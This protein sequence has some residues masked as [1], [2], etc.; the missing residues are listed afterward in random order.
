[1][2]ELVNWTVAPATVAPEESVTVPETSPVTTVCAGI[3]I[4]TMIMQAMRNGTAGKRRKTRDDK[5][6]ASIT[7]NRVTNE[8]ACVM[9]I[10]CE[11]MDSPVTREHC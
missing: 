11:H 4:G 2:L 9:K 10:L 5:N 3:A 7:A 6:E 8:H 1:V